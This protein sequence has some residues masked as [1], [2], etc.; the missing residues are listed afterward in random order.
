MCGIFG[1]VCQQPIRRSQVPKIRR[2]VS[3][4]ALQNASRGRDATGIAVVNVKGHIHQYRKP[5]EVY[6]AIQLL[7]W[8]RT[9]QK[10][11]QHTTMILGHTR[12]GTHG[13]NNLEN[14]HPFKIGPIVGTHNGVIDNYWELAATIHE[15]DSRTLFE[16]LANVSPDKLGT[17]LEEV[18]GS[19]ALAFA[20]DSVPYLVRN[21]LSPC[22]IAAP[23]GNPC[24]FVYSSEKRALEIAG[25]YADLELVGLRELKAARLVQFPWK[26]K[27][28]VSALSLKTYSR[29]L[30]VKKTD[31]SEVQQTQ[32]LMDLEHAKTQYN[33]TDDLPSASPD[34]PPVTVSFYGSTPFYVQKQ[35]DKVYTHHGSG[36]VTCVICRTTRKED[37]IRVINGKCMCSVCW[38]DRI[39]YEVQKNSPWEQLAPHDE[40]TEDMGHV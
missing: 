19:F 27:A 16:Y 35:E 39:T 4:L 3:A 1:V 36:V 23:I 38:E 28:K 40:L 15:N 7:P 34:M 12:Q 25:A 9:L 21:S 20:Y 2:L 32:L 24:V 30:P 17:A 14:T 5:K 11:S 13:S 31:S 29:H 8:R 37:I 18:E 10:I 6:R 22:W 26:Q 33:T